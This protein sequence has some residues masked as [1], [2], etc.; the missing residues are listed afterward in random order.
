LIDNLPRFSV[1]YAIANYLCAVRTPRP[2]LAQLLPVPFDVL[3]GTLFHHP[4]MRFETE[5]A[6]PTEIASV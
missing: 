4:V 3:V 2:P 1:Y 5:C 6:D